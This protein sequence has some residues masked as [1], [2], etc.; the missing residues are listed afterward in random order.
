[1]WRSTS[2]LPKTPLARD[3]VDACPDEPVRLL[4]RHDVRHGTACYVRMRGVWLRA[5]L[6]E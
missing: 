1:M 6:A 4:Q 3:S 5:M 2:D